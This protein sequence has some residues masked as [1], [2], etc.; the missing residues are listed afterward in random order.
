MLFLAFS[1]AFSQQIVIQNPVLPGDRPDPT[2]IKVG[3]FYYASAT[4][5]EWAPLFPIF[6]SKDMIHWEVVNYVF[7]EGAP[8][9]AKNNFWAPNFPMMKSRGKFTPITQLVI[10]PATDSVSL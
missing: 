7:P 8:D 2:L 10:K 3:E 1:Q 4:S 5:N 6:K 9:W